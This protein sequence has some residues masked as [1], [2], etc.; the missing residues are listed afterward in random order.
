MERA[1]HLKGRL[2]AGDYLNVLFTDEKIFTIQEVFNPQ[3][4]RF[5]STSIATIP[6]GHC[7]VLQQ[8][9]PAG[10]MVWV[11]ITS[12]YHTPLVFV[13]RGVKLN[14]ERY[15]QT[16]L[17]AVVKP[18]ALSTY[19]ARR[20]TFQQDSAPAHRARAR[21]AGRASLVSPA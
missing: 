17:E 6:M 9:M 5:Y 16:I 15:R 11:G 12:E 18:W 3:N 21:H 14:A 10:I 20:W 4:D 13:E 1:R 7:N 8:Q 2:A 19:G